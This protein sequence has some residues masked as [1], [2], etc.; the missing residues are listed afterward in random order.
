MIFYR[1]R[2]RESLCVSGSVRSE[3]ME[4]HQTHRTHVFDTTPAITTSPSS[5]IKVPPTSCGIHVCVCVDRTVYT[6]MT[7]HTCL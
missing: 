3:Q 2:E 6:V 7:R 1:E 4:W 5:P